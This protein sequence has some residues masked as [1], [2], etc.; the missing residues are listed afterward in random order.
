[1][2]QTRWLLSVLIAYHLCAVASHALP[3]PASLTPIAPSRVPGSPQSRLSQLL[4]TPLDQSA[5]IVAGLDAALVEALRP[6]RMVTAP[7]TSAGLRQYWAMFADPEQNR[8]YVRLDYQLVT[9]GGGGVV[10]RELV[11]PTGQE[12][13][14]RVVHQ[15]QDKAVLNAL[16]GF[17]HPEAFQSET[18]TSSDR[19]ILKVIRYFASRMLETRPAGTQL[20]RT[21]LWY[22]VAPILPTAGDPDAAV[23]HTVL[24]PYAA[25]PFELTGVSVDRAIGLT[26]VEG[27]ITW[28]LEYVDTP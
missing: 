14:V 10:L 28:H 17:H 11:F 21:G 24:A 20:V 15:F 5:R 12:G 18:G 23:R 25:G 13:Q 3:D 7:Y 26:E 16:D 27:P 1:M 19:E 4:S 22:G 2:S 8:Q 6:V 9:P